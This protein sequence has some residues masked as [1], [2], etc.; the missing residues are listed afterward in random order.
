MAEPVRD[1]K[2]TRVFG[3]FAL[4]G[5]S[6]KMVSLLLVSVRKKL[7]SLQVW[8]P[9]YESRLHLKHSESKEA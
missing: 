8:L 2:I 3:V 5:F 4:A 1:E 6:D 7:T 9:P